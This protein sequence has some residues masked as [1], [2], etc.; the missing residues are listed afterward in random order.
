MSG[1]VFRSRLS[2]E[3]ATE[4]Q[5]LLLGGKLA[6]IFALGLGSGSD[7]SKV[8]LKL[9]TLLNHGSTEFGQNECSTVDVVVVVHAVGNG[10]E[11]LGDGS[12]GVE[13]AAHETD[14]SRGI[15]A[16]QKKVSG[17]NFIENLKTET[18]R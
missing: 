12:L 7:T 10:S 2:N 11:R 6:L 9:S 4:Q 17:N 5:N 13:G 14:G 1:N 8:L 15:Y 16:A 18:Y 3:S